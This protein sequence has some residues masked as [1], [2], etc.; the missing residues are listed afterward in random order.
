MM[1]TR[2]EALD[3]PRKSRMNQ[4][5]DILIAETAIS[6]NLTL[7]SNDANLRTLTIEFGGHAIDRERFM[8]ATEQWPRPS[9]CLS[10][11][12]PPQEFS[13]LLLCAQLVIPDG[14]R[15]R[16]CTVPLALL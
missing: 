9:L 16:P 6:N 11:G 15:T 8:R 5:C 12:S 7:V 4:A 2:L 1:R 14:A 10:L 3:K 13:V